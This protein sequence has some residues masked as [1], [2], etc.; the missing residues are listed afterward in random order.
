MKED[1]FF[2]HLVTNRRMEAGQII[3]YTGDKKNTLYEF[4]FEKKFMNSENQDVNRI[5]SENISDDGLTLNAEDSNIVNRYLDNS[6]RSIRETIAEMVRIQ[7][8]PSYPSRLRCL[9]VTRTYNEVLEW[10]K[11]FES[12]NRKI[13]QIVKLKTD[14]NYFVGDGNYL[15]D[16][17][18]T[19]FDRKI[20]QARF[21]W[22]GY[23]DGVFPEVLID[24]NIEVLEIIDDYELNK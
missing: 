1:R 24:G 6:S 4:F 9:Y 16:L 5:V 17:E 7:E 18:T 21:Y 19:S 10:K 22:K 11:V 14:G 3:S 2:Y 15:P 8:F 13:I 12:Y 23:S 20:E